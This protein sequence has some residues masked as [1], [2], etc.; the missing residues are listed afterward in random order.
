MSYDFK[1]KEELR[2]GK[3]Y[4]RVNVELPPRAG[5]EPIK[6]CYSFNVIEY[7]TKELNLDFK[8]FVEGGQDLA[9]NDKTSDER[10]QTWLAELHSKPSVKPVQSQKPMQSKRKR[11][12]T[13]S[14]TVP[15]TINTREG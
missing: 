10:S 3:K 2:D 15:P 8:K 12:A 1:H 9:R 11:R 6:T 7:L 5:A 13:K 14:A 4:I